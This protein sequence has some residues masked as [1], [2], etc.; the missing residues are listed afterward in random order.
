MG[1]QS[2]SRVEALFVPLAQ[3]F[4]G[5]FKGIDPRPLPLPRKEVSSSGPEVIK[6]CE[7]VRVWNILML[8]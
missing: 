7:W 5:V 3:E 1:R 8:K 2:H 6:L 4:E